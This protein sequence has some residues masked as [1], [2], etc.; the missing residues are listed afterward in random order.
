M[1]KV[2]SDC[3]QHRMGA[4]FKLHTPLTNIAQKLTFLQPVGVL[5]E[6]RQALLGQLL[7]SEGGVEGRMGLMS[8]ASMV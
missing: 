5:H 6:L 8:R 1:A 4:N 3:L 7:V 2:L